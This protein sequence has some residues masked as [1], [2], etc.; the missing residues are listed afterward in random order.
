MV[1][2]A[3]FRIS[4]GVSGKSRALFASLRCRSGSCSQIAKRALASR[5]NHC[6]ISPAVLA[7]PMQKPVSSSSLHTPMQGEC[8]SA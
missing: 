5:D 7:Q 2:A 4:A 8:R 3:H 1:V 6:A